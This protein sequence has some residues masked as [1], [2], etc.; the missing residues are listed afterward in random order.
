M[1]RVSVLLQYYKLAPNIPVLV[2]WK[3]CEGVELIVNVD[4]EQPEVG[5]ACGCSQKDGDEYRVRF[6]KAIGC[7][8]ALPRPAGGVT[9]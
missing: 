4:S 1:P 6:Q 3:D 8:T 9:T 2:R 5:H 7:T